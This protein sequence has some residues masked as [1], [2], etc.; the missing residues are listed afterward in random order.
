MNTREIITNAAFELFREFP[1]DA[2][3][4]QMILNRSGVSRKTF[5]KYFPDK[6]VLM[7]LYYRNY[8]DHNIRENFNGHNYNEVLTNLFEFV[9]SERAYFKH[10]KDITGQDSFW[11]FLHQYS[12][13]FYKSIH[14][15]NVRRDILREDEQLTIILIVDGELSVFQKLIENRI[16]LSSR[17]LAD[18][19]CAMIPP[20]FR[21]CDRGIK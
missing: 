14:C 8:M 11:A 17:E 3:S 7:K 5:Y 4:V 1:F 9:K 6:Y 20:S 21:E 18:V 2:I 10:V 19:F 15:R 13:D 16:S 12:F